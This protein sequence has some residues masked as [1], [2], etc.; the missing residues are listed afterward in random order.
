MRSV[1]VRCRT[2][3]GDLKTDYFAVRRGALA[4]ICFEGASIGPSVDFN[5]PVRGS[6][7]VSVRFERSAAN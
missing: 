5:S 4:R 6:T 1:F 3:Y 7:T 2:S